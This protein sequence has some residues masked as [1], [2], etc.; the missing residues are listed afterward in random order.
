MKI[1]C[2]VPYC[3][4]FF[5]F[6]DDL[7]GLTLLIFP[8]PTVEKILSYVVHF[9]LTFKIL[10]PAFL[11]L[12]RGTLARTSATINTLVIIKQELRGCSSPSPG[13]ESKGGQHVSLVFHMR[14][15]R[16]A[17]HFEVSC[18]ITNQGLWQRGEANT[19]YAEVSNYP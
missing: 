7:K 12:T 1:L 6:A 9:V 10:T 19:K 11:L 8:P 16:S 18:D 3:F 4:F 14:E 13:E 15:G 2:F 17:L 5:L